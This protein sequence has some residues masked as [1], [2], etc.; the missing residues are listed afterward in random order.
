MTKQEYETRIK[1]TVNHE[2]YRIIETVYAH[3]PSIDEITGKDQI[4]AI[5]SQFGMRVIKDMVPT[6]EQAMALETEMA[7][8]RSR[9]DEVRAAY[10]S[11]SK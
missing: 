11:L 7:H 3:H 9:L 5:Y 10:A 8:L 2:D 6:A 1:T 4:A